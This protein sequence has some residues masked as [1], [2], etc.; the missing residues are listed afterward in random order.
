V[1]DDN[2]KISAMARAILESQ[3]YEAISAQ[4]IE[5][6]KLDTG[7]LHRAETRHI[8]IVFAR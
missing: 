1:V 3:G 2:E 7:R 5:K 6:V 8:G 4:R